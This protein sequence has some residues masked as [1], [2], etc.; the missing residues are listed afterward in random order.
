MNSSIAGFQEK[1]YISSIEKLSFYLA[2]VKICGNIYFG[3]Q[4]RKSIN[5]QRIKRHVP[6]ILVKQADKRM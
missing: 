2:H 3:K 5:I 4:R 6:L 1:Y